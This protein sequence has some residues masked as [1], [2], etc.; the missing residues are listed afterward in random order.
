MALV[1]ERSNAAVRRAFRFVAGMALAASGTPIG[2]DQAGVQSPDAGHDDTGGCPEDPAR[3]GSPYCYERAHNLDKISVGFVFT[4]VSS[5][6]VG[7]AHA[8]PTP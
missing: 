1:C 8:T 2:C 3:G 7:I 4:A 5:N 6:I